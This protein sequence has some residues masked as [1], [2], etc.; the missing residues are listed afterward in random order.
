M[1]CSFE[2]MNGTFYHTKY[3]YRVI[4]PRIVS[5]DTS[6]SSSSLSSYK[7]WCCTMKKY[8]AGYYSSRL[9]NVSYLCSNFFTSLVD[10]T[11]L[12]H[13]LFSCRYVRF[14]QSPNQVLDISA[15]YFYLINL[16]QYVSSSSIVTS[17]W[18]YEPHSHGIQNTSLFIQSAT[19]IHF[20][21]FV[22][23]LIVL[24]LSRV[25]LLMIELSPPELIPPLVAL[26]GV[27]DPTTFCAF[28]L[29]GHEFYISC[30]SRNIDF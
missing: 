18:V 27:A 13:S 17:N 11:I 2:S 15:I 6:P 12:F 20:F 9:M 21:V 3:T 29:V 26:S 1:Q 19:L 16:S 10:G 8:W 28:S 22:L 5:Y 4:P 23:Y 14:F 7:H 25:I 30:C 24:C